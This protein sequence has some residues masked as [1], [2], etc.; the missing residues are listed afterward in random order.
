MTTLTSSIPRPGRLG[1][2][3]SILLTL[4]FFLVSAFLFMGMSQGGADSLRLAA[5]GG[6]WL[7]FNAFFFLSVRSGK[8]DRYR[9][10]LFI[11]VA[12][13]FILSFAGNI[14]ELRGSTALTGEDVVS[15]DTPF[16]HLVIPMIIIPAAFTKT[17]IFPGSMLGAYGIASMLVLWLGSSLALGRG[18]CSWACFYGGLDEA[19]SRMARKP[20]IKKIDRR[21]IHTP[22]AVLLGVV[23]ISAVTLS[24]V[25][26]EWLCPFKAVTESAAVT[27][28]TAIIQTIIFVALFLG[29]VVVLPILTKKRTQ[30]SLFCPF[31][32][33]QSLTNK[34]NPYE[35]RID[36]ETCSGCGKC[37]RDCPTY[38]L[39][40]NSLK[41]GHTRLSCTKCG[42]C[43]DA[44][45]KGAI[46]YHIKGTRVG[47]HPTA[48]RLLFLCPPYLML[49]VFG[50]GYISDAVYRIVKLI[51]T[52]SLV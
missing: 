34:V 3:K 7:L 33:M 8:T 39:D 42:K 36:T 24:P 23:L 19:C 37:V 10:V 4:P 5:F 48:A 52:G 16:C 41:S 40:E 44:C 28:T 9:A 32:A 45:P 14:T 50:S 17:I 29:L 6:A 18:W 13:T 47:A 12:L 11:I 15:G 26:C 27:T 30:C 38:S 51:T 35:V 49:F 46:T 20:L 31:G 43:V 21:F 1:I 25:Y 22:W 2:G